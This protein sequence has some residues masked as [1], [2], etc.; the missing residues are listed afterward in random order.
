MM[1]DKLLK[2]LSVEK[3]G[4]NTSIFADINISMRTLIETFVKMTKK[5]Q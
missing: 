3:I 5:Y 4:E 1:L 2:N